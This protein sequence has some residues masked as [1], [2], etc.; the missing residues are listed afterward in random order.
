M[1]ALIKSITNIIWWFVVLSV[2]ATAVGLILF[3]QLSPYIDGYRSHVERNLTQILGYSVDIGVLEASLIGVNPSISV[4]D[5]RLKV[6]IADNAEIEPIELIKLN[7]ELDLVK[8]LI[9]LEPIF[10]KITFDKA[11][12]QL[13][14]KNG[15]WG[16]AGSN[17]KDTNSNDGFLRGLTYLLSQNH[18][19]LFDVEIELLDETLQ[20][21]TLLSDAI[22]LQRTEKGFGVSGNIK[23]S[24]YP[25]KL[26][27]SGQWLG[28]LNEPESLRFEAFIKIPEISI[29]AADLFSQTQLAK[30]EV[31]L[32]TDLWLAYQPQEDVTLSGHLM[33]GAQDFFER[34]YQVE[35]DF[36][37]VYGLLDKTLDLDLVDLLISDSVGQSYPTSNLSASVDHFSNEQAISIKFDRLDLSLVNRLASPFLPSEWFVSK[38]LS[39]MQLKGHAKNGELTLLSEE[40]L[41]YRYRSN[42]FVESAQGYE[43]IPAVT[44]LDTIFEL[45]NQGGSIEFSS[46]QSVI[47]LP[48]LLQEEIVT[49]GVSGRVA[50]QQQQDAIVLTGEN[51]YVSH[52]QANING[53]FRF[54]AADTDERLFILNLHGENLSFSNKLNYL[55]KNVLPD[56]AIDW[57]EQNLL[58]GTVDELDLVVQAPLGKTLGQPH[59]LLNL[60][61]RDSQIRFADDWPA[62]TQVLADFQLD[63]SG[64]AVDVHHA[65]L[66]QVKV[67][68]LQVNLPFENKQIT[69][70]IIAGDVTENGNDILTLLRSTALQQSVLK[71][72]ESWQLAGDIAANYHLAIPF[73]DDV[74]PFNLA[75]QLDFYDNDLT[76]G[77]LNLPIHIHSGHFEYDSQTG[78]DNSSFQISALGG[79]ANVRLFGVQPVNQPVQ[80]SADLQGDADILAIANWLKFPNKVMDYLGGKVNLSGMLEINKQAVGQ[81]DLTL[82]SN[83]NGVRFDLPEPLGKLAEEQENIALTIKNNAQ[84]LTVETAYR[85][86]KIKLGFDDNGFY[87]SEIFVN[88]NRD[89]SAEVAQG[90]VLKGSI[91]SYDHRPWFRFFNALTVNDEVEQFNFTVPEWLKEVDFIANK[92]AVNDDN[93]L[94]NVKMLYDNRD[95]DAGYRILADELAL[96]ITENAHGPVVH[97]NYLSW[98]T[99]PEDKG[100]SDSNE[101]P[102]TARQIPDATFSVD[103]LYIDTKPYGDWTLVTHNEGDLLRISPI[104]SKLDHGNFVGSLLWLDTAMPSVQFTLDIAGEKLEEVATKFAN[105]AFISSEEYKL[106]FVFNWQGSPFSFNN[107]TLS[108]V[109]SLFAENGRI[110]ALD[111]MPQFLKTLGIF[112]LNALTRRLT[113]DFSDINLPGLTYDSLSAELDIKNGILTTTEPLEVISPT[114]N[115]T[116]E[117]TANLIEEIFDEKLT[118]SFPLGGTLPIAGLLLGA[119]PQT[120]GLVFLTDKLLGDPLSK[121]VSIQYTI[122]GPFNEPVIERVIAKPRPNNRNKK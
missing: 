41:E 49:Q 104:R 112:N 91:D 43:N 84:K 55:P 61:S 36:K 71:P 67:N 46:S 72:F 37:L 85:N 119:T 4:S 27:F 24:N 62:A 68:E 103:E 19:A 99:A 109:V 3:K 38:M 7:V 39:S 51:L 76:I 1:K 117:G 113:L 60:R 57:I 106:A 9:S 20:S 48:Y 11:Q 28:N 25:E 78:I 116:L 17:P 5:I 69:R 13:Q 89:F 73:N 30:A 66:D 101:A 6:P 32:A 52:D 94:N 80:V 97:F 44:N 53:S 107:E 65:N 122:K 92:V 34:D 90:V 79:D 115:A 22:Y 95:P 31:K 10:S 105:D 59:T 40:T 74:T 114:I 42:V 58:S 35:S 87:G 8:S 45:D 18:I 23:H 81:L 121:V 16:L 50:W 111:T 21:T 86:H 100:K 77:S 93:E 26:N 70:L 83:L 102:F 118:A 15:R 14:K 108:G 2:V 98:N 63:S 33:F 120:A 75:L 56:K 29:P 110:T 96:K 54:E 88:D 82:N 47:K 12:I 64:I